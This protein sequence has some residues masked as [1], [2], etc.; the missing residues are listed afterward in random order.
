VGHN[1]IIDI[2]TITEWFLLKF[3]PYL[4]RV[5]TANKEEKHDV[6]VLAVK[7]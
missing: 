7:V 5:F 6:A 2:Q 3:S 4:L 1:I